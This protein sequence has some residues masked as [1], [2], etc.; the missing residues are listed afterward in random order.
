MA[1]SVIIIINLITVYDLQTLEIHTAPLSLS[2]SSN[3]S[4]LR[5]LLLVL[6]VLHPLHDPPAR[7]LRVVVRRLLVL[8]NLLHLAEV[9][10]HVHALV[11]SGTLL[12]RLQPGLDL[13]EAAGFDAGPF[14]PV[15]C[16]K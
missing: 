2:I 4:N 1:E 11:D 6:L 7:L 15:D 9:I 13:G 10:G 12:D 8:H 14:A 16:K 5:L 3:V